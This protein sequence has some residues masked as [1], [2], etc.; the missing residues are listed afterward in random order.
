MKLVLRGQSKSQPSL[1]L[2]CFDL[3]LLIILACFHRWFLLRSSA[4]HQ[5]IE[6]RAEFSTTA[7]SWLFLYAD[8]MESVAFVADESA[9]VIS[10]EE[11]LG[12]SDIAYSSRRLCSS[13]S[14]EVRFSLGTQVRSCL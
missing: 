14:Q 13:V 9:A 5:R 12:F 4:V 6:Q 8:E 11:L 2:V 1:G 3:L 10:T 7:P